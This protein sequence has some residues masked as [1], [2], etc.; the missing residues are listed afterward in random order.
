MTN[1]EQR[2]GTGRESRIASFVA[3]VVF[4]SFPF[5]IPADVPLNFLA[6]SVAAV[7]AYVVT[8][9]VLRHDSASDDEKKGT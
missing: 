3:G 4:L 2:P 1:D 7:L 9:A 8:L 6:A 5:A